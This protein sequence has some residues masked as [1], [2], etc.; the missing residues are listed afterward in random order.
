MTNANATINENMYGYN[1]YDGPSHLL[2][3]HN[4]PTTYLNNK[5]NDNNGDDESEED[6]PLIAGMWMDGDSL[7]RAKE[8]PSIHIPAINGLSS[9]DSSSPLL[10]LSLLFKY[11]V[12]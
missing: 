8:S 11:V 12:G 7:A 1:D 4:H 6:N 2:S 9:S 3:N 10:S 5:D